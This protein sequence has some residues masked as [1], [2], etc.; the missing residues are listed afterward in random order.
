[1]AAL[2]YFSSPGLK[3]QDEEEL[4]V[5]ANAP[6]YGWLGRTCFLLDHHSACRL[7]ISLST[8][9]QIRHS[10]CL[11]CWWVVSEILLNNKS[12]LSQSSATK[13]DCL[14]V[15]PNKADFFHRSV[16]IINT[17]IMSCGWFMALRSHHRP[18][19]RHQACRSRL[20]SVRP[21]SRPS[22]TAHSR[23]GSCITSALTPSSTRWVSSVT[24]CEA[25][26]YLFLCF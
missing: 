5:L 15:F 6:S 17:Q 26:N 10:T 21:S 4:T 13:A 22:S 24:H 3:L 20:P 7:Q 1:M 14:F 16:H 8:A 2:S 25:Q 23:T 9:H 12:P 11:L 18:Q 19:G